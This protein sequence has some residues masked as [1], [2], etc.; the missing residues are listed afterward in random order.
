[1]DY[2]GFPPYC[3]WLR[4]ASIVN[5]MKRIFGGEKPIFD[6]SDPPPEDAKEKVSKRLGRSRG[7]RVAAAG[8]VGLATGLVTY[9]VFDDDLSNDPPVDAVIAFDVAAIAASTVEG[10]LAHRRAE[11]VVRAFAAVHR[12]PGDGMG[13]TALR[14]DQTGA[15]LSTEPDPSARTVHLSVASLADGVAGLGAGLSLAQLAHEASET[16]M[17]GAIASTFV[18]MGGEMTAHFTEKEFHQRID[19]IAGADIDVTFE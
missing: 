15:Q 2:T 16:S 8:L 7:I 6:T 17:A 12:I 4:K 1:M 18:F 3:L 5:H 14:I 9:N 10:S 19:N 11:R 13:R